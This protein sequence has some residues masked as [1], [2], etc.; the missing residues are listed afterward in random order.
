ME[1]YRH[2]KRGSTY[3][4]VGR[5]KIQTDKPLTDM[6]NVIIYIPHGDNP[7][8]GGSEMWVRPTEEFFDGRFERYIPPVLEVPDTL[9]E[10]EIARH[11]TFKIFTRRQIGNYNEFGLQFAATG[12]WQ[13]FQFVVKLIWVDIVFRFMTFKEYERRTLAMGPARNF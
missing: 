3:E 8:D 12:K 4:I 10:E 6:M 7:F 13:G 5:G 2:I 11:R 9:T 1:T